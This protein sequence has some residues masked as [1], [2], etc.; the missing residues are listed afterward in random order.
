MSLASQ[1]TQRNDQLNALQN[2]VLND[3]KRLPEVLAELPPS[4]NAAMNLSMLFIGP[5][6]DAVP[7]AELADGLLGWDDTR[8]MQAL[9][10]VLSGWL[11]SNPDPAVD[12]IAANGGKLNPQLLTA[13]AESFAGRDAADAAAHADRLSGEVRDDWIAAVAVPYMR[14]NPSA[15]LEWLGRFQ[16][17][18]VYERTLRQIAAVAADRHPRMVAQL[19]AQASAGVQVEAAPSVAAALAGL[20]VAEAARWAQSLATAPA[21]EQ[22]ILTLVPSLA[23]SN[24][25]EARRLAETYVSDPTERQRALAIIERAAGR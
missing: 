10:S 25:A 12:W 17:Q 8:S 21:R 23:R 4:A 15:A 22:A 5:R 7:H 20:D 3:P 24:P 9:G 6:G 19:V 2:I 11:N 1:G 16:G 13:L 14:S 18:P